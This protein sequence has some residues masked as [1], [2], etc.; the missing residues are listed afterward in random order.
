MKAF[1]SKQRLERSLRIQT[2]KVANVAYCPLQPEWSVVLEI[3]SCM[4]CILRNLH[5]VHIEPIYHVYMLRAYCLVYSAY[6]FYT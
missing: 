1:L 6:H 4:L 3:A 2:Q 5:I